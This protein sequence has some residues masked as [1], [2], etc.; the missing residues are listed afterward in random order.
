MEGNRRKTIRY[1]SMGKVGGYR[2]EAKRKD[3]KKGKVSVR[4]KV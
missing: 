1:L 4:K 3:R 2:T